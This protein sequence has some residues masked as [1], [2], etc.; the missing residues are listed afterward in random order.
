MLKLSEAY[1]EHP[2]DGFTGFLLSYSNSHRQ[3]P[4][5]NTFLGFPMKP[6]FLIKRNFFNISNQLNN[7]QK[8]H[9]CRSENELLVVCINCGYGKTDLYRFNGK[10]EKETTL[11]ELRIPQMSSVKVLCFK[12][13]LV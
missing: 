8:L 2:K 3:F 11:I 12:F 5:K 6:N 7:L 13:F 4:K 1:G 10:F 9:R